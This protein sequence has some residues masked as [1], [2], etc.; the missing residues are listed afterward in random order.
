MTRAQSMR[1]SEA[2]LCDQDALVQARIRLAWGRVFDGKF[3]RMLATDFDL[4]PREVDIC[5][6]NCKG[7]PLARIG[8]ALGI[9]AGTVRKHGESVRKKVGVCKVEQ[10]IVKLMLARVGQMEIGL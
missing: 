9:S 6:L 10:V 8:E 4:S 3:A 2:V 1:F 7:V 5:V